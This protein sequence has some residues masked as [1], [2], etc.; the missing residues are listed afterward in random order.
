MPQPPRAL[1]ERFDRTQDAAAVRQQLLARLGQHQ[2]TAYTVEERD[3]ERGFK[4]CDLTGEGGLRHSQSQCR[5]GHGPLLGDR[6]NGLAG[7]ARAAEALGD[8]VKARTYYETLLAL[9][10]GSNANRPELATARRFL[11]GY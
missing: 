7:A 11:A 6:Y 10:T 4:C 1:A 3:T 8:K 5:P 9:V 2:A